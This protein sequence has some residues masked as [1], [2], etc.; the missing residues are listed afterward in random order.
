ME[1]IFTILD[2]SRNDVV[3]ESRNEVV[4][5]SGY[6]IHNFWVIIKSLLI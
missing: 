5:K 2:E 6:E 1:I 4:D 3:D